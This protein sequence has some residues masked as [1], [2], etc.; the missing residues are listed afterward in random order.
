MTFQILSI[1]SVLLV[2]QKVFLINNMI[3]FSDGITWP[4]HDALRRDI[5][6][7]VEKKQ[8]RKFKAIRK[9]ALKLSF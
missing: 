2:E 9:F 6:Q 4:S 5:S 7:I 8:A 1:L 3:D